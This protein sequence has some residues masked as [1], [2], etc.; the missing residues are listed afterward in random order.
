MINVNTNIRVVLQAKL[1]QIKQLKDNPDPIMRTVAMAVLP[2]LLVR[3]HKD[4]KDSSGGQIGTYSPGYM[5]VRTGSYKNAG[6]NDS[7]FFTKGNSAIFSVKTKKAAKVKKVEGVTPGSGRQRYNRSSDTKVILSLTRQ[8]ERDLSVIKTGNGY[9]I[10]YL[11][12]HNYDKALWCEATYNKKILTK[13]T[14]E[15]VELAKVTAV[16]FLPEYFKTI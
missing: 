2:E 9:G 8:M 15:E 13:L 10:G 16:N 11:N 5:A 7:G 14:K 4:G 12:S 6:K 3:V 1:E